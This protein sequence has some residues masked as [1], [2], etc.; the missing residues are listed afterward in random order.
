MY[1]S[2]DITVQFVPQTYAVGEDEGAVTVTVRATGF[3]DPSLFGVP[4]NVIV[5]LFTE[6][7]TATSEELSK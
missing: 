6:D 5:L 3:P 1:A 4:D 7:G 2:T